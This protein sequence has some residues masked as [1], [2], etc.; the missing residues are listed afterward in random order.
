M[1]RSIA[2]AVTYKYVNVLESLFM[3]SGAGKNYYCVIQESLF[4]LHLRGCKL[5]CNTR[6][7]CVVTTKKHSKIDLYKVKA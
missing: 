2:V 7:K 1:L 5:M 4:N 3:R 6:V